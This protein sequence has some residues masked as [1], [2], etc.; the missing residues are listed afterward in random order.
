MSDA[1]A[2]TPQQA[3]LD[4]NAVPAFIRR[5]PRFARMVLT[6]FGIAFAF[7]ATIGLLL[8]GH[9]AGP[10]TAV[11]ILMGMGIGII[12]GVTAAAIA[13][14]FDDMSMAAARAAAAAQDRNG[15]P[16]ALPDDAPKDA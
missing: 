14:R 4:A 12:G 7:G 6:G 10:R 13:T 16:W 1:D 2:P 11:A 8:P 9:Q 15:A 5:A 3:E